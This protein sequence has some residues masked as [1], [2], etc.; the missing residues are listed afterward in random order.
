MKIFFYCF[1]FPTVLGF[2]LNATG[3][4]S[5]AAFNSA[6]SKFAGDADFKHATISLFVINNTTGKTVTEVNTQTGLAPASTQKTITA[7]T[8]FA[9]LGKDFSYKT[10]LGI[11]GKIKDSILHG[12]VY[13]KGS[14]DPTLGSW[15][16]AQTKDNQIIETFKNA[17]LSKGIKDFTGNV[18]VD[19]NEWPGE[20]TPDG[21]I[22]QDIGN[23]YGAGARALN[24]RENQYDL[25]LQSGSKIGDTVKM[26]ST[27]PANVYGLNLECLVTSEKKGSGDNT[28]IYLPFNKPNGYVRGTIPVNENSFT[29]SG[30]MPQ[31]EDQLAITLQSAIKNQPFENIAAN[32]KSIVTTNVKP[33][34]FFEYTSPHLDSIAY[35][36]L[37]KSINLYGEALL[38][39][40]GGIEGKS[41]TTSGGLKVVKSFWEKQGI[42]N[43]ALNMQDG[44]G[45]SPGN[46]ITTDDLVKVLMYAKK[47]SWFDA[48]YDAFPVINDIK[49][50]SGSI[51]GVISYTGFVK[52]K[53]G[54]EYTFA[55]IVNNYNGSGNDTRRKMWKLL[56]LLK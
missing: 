20:V 8:A 10:F 53:S 12:D 7:A 16:Y 40:L 3:Q 23:Y 55:F 42:D 34:Y 17:L 49:M 14:G 46:R 9:L 51:N 41:S 30:S 21:W 45:L 11:G 36:F 50:K 29:I 18:I 33:D 19:L 26:I 28:Y 35:W 52:S 32:Y 4:V 13:I 43:Y 15:R 6:F 38:K 37:K 39:T 56:D 48:Y 25:K 31:P 22:W 54:Q 24:W 1:L 27:M 44:S 5:D 47:Q 2:A